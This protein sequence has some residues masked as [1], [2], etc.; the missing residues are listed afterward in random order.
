MLFTT[1]DNDIVCE[2]ICC[3]CLRWRLS[4]DVSDVG[5]TT[6]IGHNRTR[7]TSVMGR[8]SR[9][10]MK[11]KVWT[12]FCREL[13][14]YFRRTR[15]PYWDNIW[16]AEG[17]LMLLIFEI[18]AP[19]ELIVAEMT[20]KSHPRS[21]SRQYHHSIDHMR[22]PLGGKEQLCSC[23]VL[24]PRSRNL[25]FPIRLLAPLLRMIAPEFCQDLW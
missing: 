5:R 9:R 10:L 12:E 14:P 1:V 2:I 11:S 18:L 22:L 7:L 24:F 3:L 25:E 13:Y 15:N 21:S 16:Y 8:N 6:V 23:L 4:T 17:W 19:D 20:V